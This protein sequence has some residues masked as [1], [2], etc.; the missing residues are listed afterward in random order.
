MPSAEHDDA[1][2]CLNRMLVEFYWTGLSP[3][4]SAS[5]GPLY[6]ISSNGQNHELYNRFEG[7][8]IHSHGVPLTA[9]K[10]ASSPHYLCACKGASCQRSSQE[11][12]AMSN[13]QLRGPFR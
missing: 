11:G 4:I 5:P 9:V 1:S 3:S 2:Y 10:F 8:N 12:M 6:R 13:P 7:G